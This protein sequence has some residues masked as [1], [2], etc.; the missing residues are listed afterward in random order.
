MNHVCCNKIIKAFIDTVILQ[1]L[2]NY[3]LYTV[4]ELVGENGLGIGPFHDFAYTFQAR[5]VTLST[6]INSETL[7]SKCQVSTVT[8]IHSSFS[9]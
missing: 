6:I 7:L 9:G 5:N 4:G 2:L 3:I 1:L 8:Q